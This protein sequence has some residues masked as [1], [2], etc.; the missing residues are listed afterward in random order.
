MVFGWDTSYL[1]E[2]PHFHVLYSLQLC[3]EGPWFY[4]AQVS[5]LDKGVIAVKC[6]MLRTGTTTWRWRVG[7]VIW[8]LSSC[9]TN[10]LWY[11]VCRLCDYQIV[12]EHLHR[13]CR[14][15]EC[16]KHMQYVANI[17][18]AGATSWWKSAGSTSSPNDPPSAPSVPDWRSSTF[19]ATGRAS[20]S[21]MT[22]TNLMDRLHR[23]PLHDTKQLSGRKPSSHYDTNH[24]NG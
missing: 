13:Q 4:P 17:L 22:P 20:T 19:L 5:R 16:W 3:R 10:A 1:T 9:G 2:A 21:T 24:L 6:K 8:S 23:P 18:C 11:N 14:Y 12:E 15:Y 7:I